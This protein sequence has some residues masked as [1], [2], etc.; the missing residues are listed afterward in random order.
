MWLDFADTAYM[1]WVLALPNLAASR[2]KICV[3]PTGRERTEDLTV[4]AQVK[5][6]P[7]GKAM[8]EGQA[9]VRLVPAAR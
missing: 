3:T 8:G 2:V 5:P 6:W 4:V 7:D 9:P 1:K